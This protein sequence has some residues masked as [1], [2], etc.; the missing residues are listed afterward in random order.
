MAEREDPDYD[1][2]VSRA[3]VEQAARRDDLLGLLAREMLASTDE[4]EVFRRGARGYISKGDQGHRRFHL[5]A[6]AKVFGVKVPAMKRL[7]RFWGI[8]NEMD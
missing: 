7:L 8:L 2:I 5:A 4:M 3:A 6:L 1:A